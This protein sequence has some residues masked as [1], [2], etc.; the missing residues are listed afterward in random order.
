MTSTR[1]NNTPG[2]YCLQQKAI[3][4]T[5]RYGEYKFGSAGAAYNP[6][7]PC[8]GY[9]PSHMP[10]S[11]FSNNSTEIESRLFGIGSTNLVK[12]QSCLQPSLRTIPFKSFFKMPA[13][14]AEVEETKGP[15]QRPFPVP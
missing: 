11:F 3:N 5:R 1:N 2:D 4:V 14:V 6:A 8:I 9:T 15:A 10:A 12:P 13:R 7:I